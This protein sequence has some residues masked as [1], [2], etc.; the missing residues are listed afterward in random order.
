MCPGFA[1]A[2]YAQ[3]ERAS[4][5]GKIT[6]STGAAMAAVEVTVT[7]EATNT[8]THV[9]TDDAGAFTAVNL[10]PGSYSVNASTKGFRP[11]VFRNFVLQV[12]Q[13]ARL[14]ITMEV[15]KV[16]QTLEVTGAVPLLQTESASV[17][18]VIEQTAVN[19]LPLNG[20]NFV[21]LAILAP[22]VSG[23]DYAQVGT[24][25]TGK[26]PDELRPG[27]AALQANGALSLVGLRRQ[28]SCSSCCC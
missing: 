19:A 11:V 16:E 22:G 13:S 9:V 28:R 17:G 18:Q 4:I 8:S 27:G 26:R 14:D 12:G 3:V 7:N 5:V 24:I 23:L 2:L 1:P 10:I 15:G 20:R 6:D 21:Q 25:N